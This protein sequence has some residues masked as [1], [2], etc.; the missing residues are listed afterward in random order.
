[1]RPLRCSLQPWVE[2][3]EDEKIPFEGNGLTFLVFLVVQCL[4]C[5]P[6]WLSGIVEGFGAVGG[7][8]VD[9]KASA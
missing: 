5:F 2:F 7:W 4:S 9:F 3:S 1:M 8:C 6:T